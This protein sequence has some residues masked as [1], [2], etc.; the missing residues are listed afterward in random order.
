LDTDTD[1]HIETWI[2]LWIRNINHELADA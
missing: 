2:A 1:G